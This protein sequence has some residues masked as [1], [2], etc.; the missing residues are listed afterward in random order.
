[1]KVIFLDI[2]GVLC[3]MRSEKAY[4]GSPEAGD[5]STWDR[6]DHCAID[7]LKRALKETDAKVVLSS[8]WRGAVNMPTLEYCLG[9]KIIDRTRDPASADELRGQ[10]IQDWLAAH[11]EVTRYAILDDDEDML[12]AQLDKL[13]RT[14]KR[15]GFLLGHYDE[16]LELLGQA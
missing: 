14:S 5:P 9:I 3:S 16:L 15:N 12:P 1:M 2:D 6:F 13:C 11:P 10:Q 8:N 7:L 4:Y